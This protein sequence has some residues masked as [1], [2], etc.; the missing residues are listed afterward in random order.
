MTTTPAIGRI[1]SILI[2]PKETWPEVAAEPSTLGA[3]YTRWVLWLAALPAIFSSIGI[4]LWW[5]ELLGMP[6][7]ALLAGLMGPG[8]IIRLFIENLIL[9]Y[10]AQV[11]TVLIL[12]WVTMALAGTFGAS[13]NLVQATKTVAYALTPVWIA[14][15]AMILPVPLLSVLVNLAG[16]GYAVYLIY[17]AVPVTTNC[18]PE[19][20]PGYTALIVIIGIV[21]MWILIKL[22]GSVLG[23]PGLY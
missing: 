15:I 21:V 12:S 4:A 22:L 2:K 11:G 9:T 23:F 17:L 3:L 18:P 10:I 1:R 14:G 7:F 16:L 6:A 13:A 8:L 19:K 5:R 20:A